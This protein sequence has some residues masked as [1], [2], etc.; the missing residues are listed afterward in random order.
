[1]R[2]LILTYVYFF[3]LYDLESRQHRNILLGIVVNAI[4]C[5]ALLTL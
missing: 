5:N 2:V 3:Y 4:H 1:M